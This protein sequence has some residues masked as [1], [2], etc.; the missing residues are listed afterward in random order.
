MQQPLD[1][2][3]IEGTGFEAP[4]IYGDNQHYSRVWSN[5]T[6]HVYVCDTPGTSPAARLESCLICVEAE[7][8]IDGFLPRE[9]LVN[10]R[11]FHKRIGPTFTPANASVGEVERYFDV[12]AERYDTTIAL[13]L[14][15][16][17]YARLL[18]GIARALPTGPL[19]L[20]DFGVGTGSALHGA[21]TQRLRPEW[22]S[23][24][25]RLSAVD[26]SQAM[27]LRAR[28]Q[29]DRWEPHIEKCGYG[30]VP[31][32]DREFDAVIACYVVHYFADDQPFQA[33]RRVLRT[34]GLFAFNLHHPPAAPT[35]AP[36]AGN[37]TPENGPP[38]MRPAPAGV[39]RTPYMQEYLEWLARAG[40][41]AVRE[42]PR[43]AVSYL[44]PARQEDRRA[45]TLIVARAI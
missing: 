9:I 20:L 32:P 44:D 19:H 23:S 33:I 30:E 27:V 11:P 42:L 37:T 45:V 5:G 2:V 26:L 8:A 38:P 21:I 4:T 41:G 6:Q 7:G 39:K 16:T 17:V 43:V 13:D 22:F 25:V 34:G 36:L 10:H 15:A 24:R 18:N 28:Q 31:L 40:F 14:N 3:L 12:L 1:R 29:L 35:R